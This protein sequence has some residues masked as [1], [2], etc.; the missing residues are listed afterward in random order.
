M[1]SR[2]GRAILV[3]LLIATV[4]GW[5]SLLGSGLG[6]TVL[7]VVALCVAAVGGLWWLT[8]RAGDAHAAVRERLGRAEDGHH[9]AFA[10][11]RLQVE[12]DGR[13]VWVG[14]AGLQKVLGQREP[15]EAQAARHA[16]A[17]RRNERG[18][19]MLRVDAAI[20]HLAT[21]P[22]RDDPRVQR[23]RRYLERDVLY[24]AQRRHEAAR[25]SRAAS[26]AGS[27]APT[28]PAARP[29]PEDPA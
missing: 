24:P 21:M 26:A 25:P 27:A 6:L 4:L 13:H 5:S 22:G 29:L 14:G 2:L 23:L 9:H 17:W 12:D 20:Q 15:E 10:G 18:L 7:A 19:L 16:G 28:P 11:V 3:G 1:N 8:Q